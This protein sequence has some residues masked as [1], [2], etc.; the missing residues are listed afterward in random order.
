MRFGGQPVPEDKIVAR[1]YRSL[2]LLS[3]ALTH[4]DRAYIFDNSGHSHIWL[5]E[6]T[7]GKKLDVK[8]DK[9]PAWFKGAILDKSGKD[10]IW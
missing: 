6:I 2:E 5:A 8:T 1:Y 4:A 9:A 3:E 10:G 7:E